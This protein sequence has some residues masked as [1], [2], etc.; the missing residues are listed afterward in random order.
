MANVDPI[1]AADENA[2]GSGTFSKRD[3]FRIIFSHKLTIL[4]T[5]LTITFVV[6]WGLWYLP[7]TYSASAKILID[8]SQE[9]NPSFFSSI[10]P[11]KEREVSDPVNRLIE[12]EMELIEAYPL[13][14]KVV[15]DMNLGYHDIYH[16]PYMRLLKPVFNFYDRMLQDYLGVKP[17]PKRDTAEDPSTVAAFIKSLRVM[18]LKSKSAETNSNII[19]VEIRSPDPEI[20]QTALT[21]LLEYYRI[22]DV[23]MNEEAAEKAAAIVQADLLEATKQL[24]AAQNRLR[25][26]A[27]SGAEISGALRPVVGSAI[28]PAAPQPVDTGSNRRVTTTPGDVSTLSRLKA[29]LIDA[30]YDLV[31]AQQIYAGDN[32][33]V[34]RLEQ[35]VSR[36]QEQIDQ[37]VNAEAANE[38][39]MAD[40]QRDVRRAEARM[41]DLD[42][43][44]DQIHL[45]KEMNARHVGKRIVIEPPVLPDESDVKFKIM[46]G[47]VASLASL[48]VGVAFAGLL[49]YTD[50]RLKTKADVRRYLGL[51]LLAT[52]PK[53]SSRA[54]N[55][56]LD[57]NLP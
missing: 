53:S 4:L 2:E 34:Q 22:F 32:P 27:S 5:F 39:E 33:K 52:V 48:V 23:K 25:L 3:F 31:Q 18:P 11:I 1:F 8:T 49:E 44:L 40:L 10:T 38:T 14:Q 46:I 7:P 50:H 28:D 51:D 35:L 55:R 6:A 16:K 21:K 30:K 56:A 45:Y 47:I 12:T 9:A 13:S 26:F 29:Q 17:D 57:R 42:R 19:G 36:L 43:K 24:E 20:A 54:I 41:I 37:E 15:T